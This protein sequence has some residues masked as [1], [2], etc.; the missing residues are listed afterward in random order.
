MVGALIVFG[1][2]DLAQNFLEFWRDIHQ[3]SKFALVHPDAFAGHPCETPVHGIKHGA[4]HVHIF[5][6]VENT[7]GR[8][9]V[10]IGVRR[11]EHFVLTFAITDINKQTVYLG[12]LA[13]VESKK[14]AGKESG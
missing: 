13:I 7:S 5:L 9:D 11:Q 1:R 6:L 3:V 8:N 4:C 14:V 2:P 12:R 10:S